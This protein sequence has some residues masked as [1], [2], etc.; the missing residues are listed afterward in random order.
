MALPGEAAAWS[1][2]VSCRRV[3]RRGVPLP[4]EGLD[5]DESLRLSEEDSRC[6]CWRDGGLPVGRAPDEGICW[7]TQVYLRGCVCGRRVLAARA[8]VS[9]RRVLGGCARRSVRNTSAGGGA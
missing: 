4:I 2:S 7:G 1:V 9:K 8:G 3:R 5:E 6:C